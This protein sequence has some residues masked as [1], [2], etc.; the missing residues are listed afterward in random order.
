VG[1]YHA[2]KIKIQVH[3]FTS[4]YVFST[5]CM[6]STF[7]YERFGLGRCLCCASLTL[8]HYTLVPEAREGLG[9][10]YTVLQVLN[11]P[12]TMGD[13]DDAQ[14]KPAEGAIYTSRFHWFSPGEGLGGLFC[15]RS[16]RAGRRKAK[17][18]RA[19]QGASR[20]WHTIQGI[21][22]IRCMQV[23][24]HRSLLLRSW[25]TC[26]TARQYLELGGGG[27]SVHTEGEGK[28]H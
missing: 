23:V 1:F 12:R 25:A 15:S 4:L 21:R 13:L 26:E 22:A 11:A 20:V 28:L 3:F 19:G 8:L 14:K 27:G 6:D 24:S 7:M 10:L 17:Q 18:G 5:L 16:S 9:G 2:K